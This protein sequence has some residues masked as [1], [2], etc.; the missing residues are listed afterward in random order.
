[1]VL[2]KS[3]R[4][5]SFWQLQTL[6]WVCFYAWTLLDPFPTLCGARERFAKTRWWLVCCSSVVV[7]CTLLAGGCC[8]VTPP[9][10]PLNCGLLACRVTIGAATA[11]A[12]ELTMRG[13]HNMR[14]VDLAVNSADF[15]FLLF[16]WSSL[17]FSIKQWHTS[18]RERE[19]L[20]CVPKRR[21]AKPGFR[22]CAIN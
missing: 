2:H 16:C 12:F 14:V 15:P 5:T 1:M 6:G 8:A 21:L 19:R 22:R 18:S 4:L 9:G 17:Y 11:F 13:I 3:L 10:S 7:Y 20:L